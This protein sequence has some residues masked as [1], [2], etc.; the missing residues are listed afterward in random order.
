[1]CP[2]AGRLPSLRLGFLILHKD[3][4]YCLPLASLTAHID[5]I[6]QQDGH[7]KWQM[8]GYFCCFHS[9]SLLLS[10][11]DKVT[12]STKVFQKAPADMQRSCG[13]VNI[14]SHRQET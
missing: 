4:N 6:Y 1:M 5:N 13:K 9:T 2:W 10:L 7:D 3:A 11:G 12:L 14:L 8:K